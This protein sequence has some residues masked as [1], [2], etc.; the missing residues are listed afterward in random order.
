MSKNSSG[1]YYQNNKEILKNT[2]IS[3]KKKK[4]K[5]NNIVVN[6]TKIYQKMENKSWLSIEENILK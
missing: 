1:K 4:K 5:S 3:L 2:K 6:D